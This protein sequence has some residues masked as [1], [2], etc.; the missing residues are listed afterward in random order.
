MEP[1]SIEEGASHSR[2]ATK[3][4]VCAA[5]T[6][7][8]ILILSAIGAALCGGIVYIPLKMLYPPSAYQII[9]FIE[10][11]VYLITALLG[12]ASMTKLR[13]MILAYMIS[14]VLCICVSL[15]GLGR[16][17]YDIFVFSQLGLFGDCGGGCLF[18]TVPICV[19]AVISLIGF[20][21]S[22]VGSIYCCKG[23]CSPSDKKTSSNMTGMD[24]VRIPRPQTS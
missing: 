14:C 18:V 22:L 7:A 5:V 19:L 20:V 3:Y 12:F 2:D 16:Y 8:V 9:A 6:T 4:S 17:C 15:A 10:S 13:C 24:R 1:V 21:T 11:G 23:V